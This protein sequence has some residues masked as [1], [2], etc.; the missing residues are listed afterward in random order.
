[1]EYSDLKNAKMTE[2]Q[3][4]RIESKKEMNK[5]KAAE[6]IFVVPEGRILS[7]VHIHIREDNKVPGIMF[8]EVLSKLG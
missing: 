7:L 3:A 1:M 4:R 8:G 2:D 6:S 5:K